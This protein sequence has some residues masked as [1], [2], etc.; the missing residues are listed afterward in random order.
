MP[1]RG[2]VAGLLAFV[3]LIVPWW[4][5]FGT[6]YA[7]L[8]WTIAGLGF[9]NGRTYFFNL[10][11]FLPI[12]ETLYGLAFIILLA[13]AVILLASGQ[14]T[15]VGASMVVLGILISVIDI[16]LSEYDYGP[17]LVMPI[18]LILALVAGIVGLT[19]KPPLPMGT[20]LGPTESSLDKLVK[21]KE[22]LDAG[23]ITEGEFEEQKRII[24]HS[25][26]E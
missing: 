18:G 7:E 13:G 4:V 14:H 25:E 10:T 24:L 16:V 12:H 19:A 9:A 20:V 23:A 5:S 11:Q 3:S 8:D 22:L 1:S 15:R 2:Q 6:D 26:E 21:L 17:F